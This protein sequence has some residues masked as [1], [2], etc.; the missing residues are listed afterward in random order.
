MGKVAKRAALQAAEASAAA[1]PAAKRRLAPED[2][3]RDI[4]AKA[5]EYFAQVGFDGGTRELAGHLGT[6]QPL[7]Y[8]YFPTK[9]ALIQ[10]I[11]KAVFLDIWQPSWDALLSDTARPLRDRLQQFY[12]EYM[13][14]ILTP[15]WIRIYFFAGLK[16]VTINIQYLAI[17]EER[18][19]KRIIREFHREMG[20]AVP[21]A[22][23]PEDLETAWTL[24]GGIFYYGV[25]K[26]VYG[27]PM[28]TSAKTVISQS[29]DV[30]CAGY[31]A[32]LEQRAAGTLR[33]DAAAPPVP[34]AKPARRAAKV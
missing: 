2:R 17:V 34:P 10:E 9:E 8:R 12:E 23:A 24:Q 3:R 5:I 30:F 32:V 22:V 18:V 26:Y 25:R 16:G 19:L 27:S 6:T 31:R 11:Y 1:E 13:A 14:A 21:D 4:L 29:L 33:A 15:Q 7:L 20:L 28:H